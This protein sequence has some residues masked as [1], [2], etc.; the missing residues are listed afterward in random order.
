LDVGDVLP[1]AGSD[2]SVLE[3]AIGSFNLASGL[4]RKRMNDLYIAVLQNLFPL[5][6]GFIGQKM[7]LSP[8]RVPSLDKSKDRVGIDI[9]GVRESIA[10][11]DALEGQNMSPAGFCL[12][13]NGIKEEPAIII[14]GSDEIP[15]L[16]GRWC[17]EMMRGVM[18]NEFSDITG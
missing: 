16:L 8:D 6:G 1:D 9:V 10:K 2:E 18:L 17:P 5:R 7:V 4:G 14:Q 11:D 12:D 3:P 13:Q 15:F